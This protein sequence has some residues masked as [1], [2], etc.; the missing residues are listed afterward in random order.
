[1]EK[2]IWISKSLTLLW[3]DVPPGE[4]DDKLI[5]LRDDTG[6]NVLIS[7]DEIKRLIEALEQ[8]ATQKGIT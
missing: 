4:H 3:D 7:T 5:T 8:V 2:S 1:M 6:G